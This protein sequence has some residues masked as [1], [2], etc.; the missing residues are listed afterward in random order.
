MEVLAV[1]VYLWD[2]GDTAVAVPA[3]GKSPEQVTDQFRR[4]VLPLLLQTQGLQSLHASAVFA[5]EGLVAFCGTSGTGKSTT[6]AALSLR[7][8]PVWADDVVA[9]SRQGGHFR[10]PGVASSSLRLLPDA[11]ER[12]AARIP[13]VPEPTVAAWPRLTAV[14]ELARRDGPPAVQRLAPGAAVTTLL[15]HAHCFSLDD[16]EARRRLSDG[17]LALAD[18]VPIFRLGFSPGLERI[19]DVLDVVERGLGL[20]RPAE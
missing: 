10:S 1:G 2:G 14:V 5:S 20:R 15:E 19:D 18:A 16:R 9:F 11:H 6:V 3:S 17:Y 4:T 8:F 12:F 13:H 7:G